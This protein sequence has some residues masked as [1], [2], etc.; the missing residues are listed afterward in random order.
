MKPDQTKKP[1]A[2]VFVTCDECGNEQPDM[3]RGV[4]CEVCGATMPEAPDAR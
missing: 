3:G 4:A 1:D 2:I